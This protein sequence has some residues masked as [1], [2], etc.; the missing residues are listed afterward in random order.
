MDPYTNLS[1]RSNLNVSKG[2]A[3]MF[4]S[5]PPFRAKGK[6]KSKE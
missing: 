3:Y 6:G 4:N 5:G 2:T 1:I